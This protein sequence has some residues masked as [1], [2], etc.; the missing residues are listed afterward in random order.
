[1]TASHTYHM[2]EAVLDVPGG[3]E[4]RTTHALSWRGG[5]TNLGLIVM[6]RPA[7]NGLDAAID[8]DVRDM[9]AKLKACVIDVDEPSDLG[10]GPARLVAIRYVREGAPFFHRQLA[11][12]LDGR[13]LTLIVAG[14]AAQRD[15][16]ESILEEAASSFRFRD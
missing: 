2:D 15:V 6:R 5:E 1:M 11:A 12:C 8:A 7:P 4:D 13:L 10:G 9:R 14:P 3:F 16:L